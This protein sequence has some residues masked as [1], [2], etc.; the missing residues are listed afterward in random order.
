MAAEG[1]RRQ[2]A[3]MIERFGK[4]LEY[5]IAKG[6]G[7]AAETCKVYEAGNAKMLGKA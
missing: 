7:K 1:G 4:G 5:E 2:D 3:E 6:V